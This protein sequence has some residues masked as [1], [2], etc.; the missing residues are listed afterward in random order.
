MRGHLDASQLLWPL[1][2][3]ETALTPLFQAN[4]DKSMLREIAAADYGDKAD[5]YY[6]KLQPVLMTGVVAPDVLEAKEVLELIRWS[7]PEDPKWSPGG[8]GIRGHWMRIFACSALVR[9][10]PSHRKRFDGECETLAQLVS[11]AIE[12][13][14]P[15]P[16]AAA[17]LLSWR[18]LTDPGADPDSAFLA[19]AILLL[20]A[21]LE[22]AE[23][24]G[25][26]LKNLAAWVED[27]E[28]RCRKALSWLSSSPHWSQWLTGLTSFDQKEAVWRS[29]AHCILARPE[30]THPKDASEALQLLG[31]L[32]AGI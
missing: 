17:S 27:E 4:I 15:V 22:H 12:L 3:D 20:A 24:S 18:F 11:S 1:E 21:H 10:A 26:W 9:L 14:C 28:S 6:T 5:Y 25:Q 8:Q 13:G 7:Q 23:G 30:R 31:E 32:V 2:P 19:F 29:L 16:R